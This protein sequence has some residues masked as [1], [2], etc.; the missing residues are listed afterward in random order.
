MKFNFRKLKNSLLSLG[1]TATL[2]FPSGLQAF[3]EPLTVEQVINTLTRLQAVSGPTAQ[4]PNRAQQLQYLIQFCNETGQ[5]GIIDG[6]GQPVAL[7][8]ALPWLQSPDGTA[9][10]DLR[11]LTNTLGWRSTSALEKELNKLGFVLE[12]ANKL[13]LQMRWI[14]PDRWPAYVHLRWDPDFLALYN[15]LP[16]PD[17]RPPLDQNRA[18]TTTEPRREALPGIDTLPFGRDIPTDFYG[19]PNVPHAAFPYK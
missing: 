13:L 14:P 5:R 17:D 15:S 18:P 10:A 4:P 2:L 16:P 1:L 9:I 7:Q 11:R 8:L 19:V 6:L 3:A 12:Q